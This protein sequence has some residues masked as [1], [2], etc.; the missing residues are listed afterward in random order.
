M[1]TEA[2]RHRNRNI[3]TGDSGATCHLT[4]DASGMFDTQDSTSTVTIGDGDKMKVMLTGKKKMTILQK[5]GDT[6][7][8]TIKVKDVPGLW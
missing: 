1:A 4:N 2:Q 7:E 5:N 8:V 3:W 6:Q